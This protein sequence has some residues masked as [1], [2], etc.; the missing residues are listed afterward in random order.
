MI[1]GRGC[2]G[3]CQPRWAAVLSAGNKGSGSGGGVS[4]AG[5]AGSSAGGF[6]SGSGAAGS[7]AAGLGCWLGLLGSRMQPFFGEKSP[8]P[9]RQIKVFRTPVVNWRRESID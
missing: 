6:A 5:G 2:G 1:S 4:A 9:I 7:G 8:S 3:C